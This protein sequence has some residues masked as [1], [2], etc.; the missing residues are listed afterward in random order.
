MLKALELVGFKSF[1][2]KTRFDFP[3]GITVVVGPNGSG[4]SNIVD[5][6]KWV[7]GEQSAK[8]L[9][10]KDMADV[11]FKGSGEG[12]RRMQNTA[13]VTI[14]FENEDGRLPLDTSEVHVTR[15]VYRSGEGEY[16]IN[17]QACRLKDIRTLFRGTG[18]GTDAYSLIEQGKVERMLQASAK[19]RRAIFEEAAGISRF[20]AKKVEAERRLARVDQNM[21]R[22]SDIVEEVGSRLRSVRSQASKAKRYREYS[23]R[24]QQL[25]TQVGLAD[26]RELSEKLRASEE[27]LASYRNLSGEQDAQA[28]TLEARCLELDVELT[29]LVESVR[30]DENR[31]ARTREQLATNEAG[32]SQGHAR[33]AELCDNELQFRLRLASMAGRAGNVQQRL[34]ETTSG[35]QEAEE[36]FDEI[37]GRITHHEKLLAEYSEALEQHRRRNED[38]RRQH[39]E[40]MQKIAAV[41]KQVAAAESRGE[42][43][44][45]TQARAQQ[46][47][48]ALQAVLAEARGELDLAQ[49]AEQ[50]LHSELEQARQDFAR[51][52][53]QLTQQE[54]H[55]E[56]QREELN[57]LR[58]HATAARER[59]A[60]LEELEKNQAGIEEGVRAVLDLA[61]SA[62]A[63]PF[64]TIQGLVADLFHV[65]VDVAPLVDVV[66]GEA[67]QHVAVLGD[68]VF[69]MIRA[70]EFRPQSRVGFVRIDDDSD[71]ADGSIDLSGFP[72]V[73]GRLDQLVDA[74]R[75][76]VPLVSKL[77]GD[78]WLV[79][80]LETAFEL[81]RSQ[82]TS[83]R[84]VTSAGEFVERNGT[85]L[86][87]PRSS[88]STLVSRR[89]ELRELATR[90]EELTAR[91]SLLEEET[92]AA[93]SQLNT[94]RE[95]VRERTGQLERMAE[96]LAEKR[97]LVKAGEQRCREVG[98]QQA[99][100]ERELAAAASG[101]VECRQELETHKSE[102]EQLEA[103]AAKLEGTL[104]EIEGEIEKLEARREHEARQTTQAQVE[105]GKSEQLLST[106]RAQVT[107]FQADHQERGKAIEE[108]HHQLALCLERQQH[109][110]LEVLNASARIASLYLQ[111]EQLEAGVADRLRSRDETTALKTSS[112]NQ[113]QALRRQ[114]QKREE[115]HHQCEIEATEFR[116]QRNTLA[117]RLREDYGIEIAELTDQ[118][119][120]ESEESEAV[121]KEIADLRRRIN[122]IGAVNTDALHELD[123]LE[124]RYASLSA[125]FED[126]NQAKEALERIIA[127][128]N[129]DSRR[130]FQETLEAI[131]VNFQA[132]YRRAFG[133]GRADLA[134]EEGV[135]VLEAGIDI[136]ATPPG[137]PSFSNSLL[138]GG[139]KALTA[140]ALLLAIFQYRPSPFCVLD[141]VDAPF[142]EANIGRFVDVL[143][144]F[145]GWTKFVVVTHSK[146]TM[147]A[148]TTLYGVT[149]QESGV[150]KR[151]SV[152]FEDVSDDG[153]ISQEAI[154]RDDSNDSDDERG[155]A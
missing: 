73:L 9:R 122:N 16:L 33:H 51:D 84:F 27:Q 126:L 5:A 32:V 1:A 117:E 30:V 128:I 92:A 12:T 145:L 28:E 104:R 40:Q 34:A 132:L 41:G 26:W 10:G 113:L 22:L 70:N 64:S 119:T 83:M 80:S 155:A 131:R 43:L 147:T 138:S 69:S 99:E 24:L 135:D 87:G 137:K 36:S 106:L 42:A 72:G 14:I 15:R 76:A 20:K 130:V 85:V 124:E 96:D 115:E 100:I 58:Q 61:Q 35:L 108:S 88:A 19:D 7:L 39:R 140:V 101:E 6:M 3:A 105:L 149:M 152:R 110:R 90:T 45:R 65:G 94:R 66:L 18:V 102:L 123:E 153:H 31:I 118:P 8:S 59:A 79:E 136:I 50:S 67:A 89:S 23:E 49:A 56:S 55:F 150:S 129:A 21:L 68:D 91:I 71:R 125:Q 82:S 37:S 17:G 107:Q 148:A 93:V 116:H 75:R 77:L 121:D 144:E 120:E 29:N 25:R 11:I 46:S 48:E 134:L 97:T 2:D 114:M 53:D 63:G 151:V 98:E 78:C 44:Q 86:V 13:E 52:Q 142:D 54:A 81:R 57:E 109:V 103:D 146:K 60:V 62:D 141:E 38:D 133:G 143:K 112:T 154:D 127:K 47:L 95:S 74:D 4:K 111:R 139:E